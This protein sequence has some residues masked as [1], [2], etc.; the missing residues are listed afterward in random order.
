MDP[1]MIP[2]G[3]SV[4]PA[5]HQGEISTF[6]QSFPVHA[7]SSRESEAEEEKEA[8]ST[9]FWASPVLLYCPCELGKLK[10]N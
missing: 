2:V 9:N 10:K 5:G 8:C 6:T 1:H 4:V 7:H 3:S